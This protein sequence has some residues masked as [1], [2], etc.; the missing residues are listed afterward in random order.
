MSIYSC[1]NYTFVID[2]TIY[3]TSYSYNLSYQMDNINAYCLMLMLSSHCSHVTTFTA[4]SLLPSKNLSVY[5]NMNWCFICEVFALLSLLA[6]MHLLVP[7][8]IFY[9]IVEIKTQLSMRIKHL[10]IQNFILAFCLAYYN[11]TYR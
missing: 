7:D 9:V 2:C 11:Y 10:C 1:T 6:N 3:W 8:T 4:L 5:R